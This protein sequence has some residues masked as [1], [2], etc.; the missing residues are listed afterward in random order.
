MGKKA[1]DGATRLA[2]N[3]YHYT[4]VNGKWR[5]THHLTAEKSLGR[6]LRSDERVLFKAGY[7]R[8]DYANADA[9]II[10]PV[11]NGKAQRLERLREKRRL[12]DEQI[13]ELEEELSSSS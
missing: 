9:L 11:M 10:R 8:R 13:R 4:K 2:P 3:G 7:D 5:L 12:I 6:P 1:A